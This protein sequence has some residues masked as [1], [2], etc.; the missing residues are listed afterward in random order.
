VAV[1]YVS[2]RRTEPKFRN[3]AVRT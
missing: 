1:G 3:T 2:V